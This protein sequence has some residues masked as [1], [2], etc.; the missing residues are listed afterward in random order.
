MQL[1]CKRLIESKCFSLDEMLDRLEFWADRYGFWR[2]TDDGKDIVYRRGSHWHALYTF[3]IRKVPTEVR[4]HNTHDEVGT[5]VCTISCG[6]WLQF[7]TPGDE[8]RLSQEMDLLEACLKGAFT[9]P[10][11]EE[12]SF[13]SADRDVNRGSQNIQERKTD[14]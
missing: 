5:C 7:S 1:T 9:A 2:S 12:G 13:P 4:I 14:R 11:A 6:S 3:D 10:N 8:R